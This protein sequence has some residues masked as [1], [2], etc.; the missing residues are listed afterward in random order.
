VRSRHGLRG[1]ERANTPSIRVRLQNFPGLFRKIQT[2]NDGGMDAHKERKK[3]VNAQNIDSIALH[4][5][6]ANRASWLRS[7][8]FQRL[9]AL[10]SL[11]AHPANAM[12]IAGDSPFTELLL[13]HNPQI[14]T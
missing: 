12:R 10:F 1:I 7:A 8:V 2:E 3:C 13:I 9:F 4:Y 14:L 6:E 5:I 11:D